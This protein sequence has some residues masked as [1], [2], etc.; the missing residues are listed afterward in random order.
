MLAYLSL[1][2][3]LY[4]S[5]KH[6]LSAFC[7]YIRLTLFYHWSIIPHIYNNNIFSYLPLIIRYAIMYNDFTF[8]YLM[9]TYFWYYILISVPP[10]PFIKCLLNVSFPISLNVYICST[11]KAVLAVFSLLCVVVCFNQKDLCI[12]YVI[13][14]FQTWLLYYYIVY[15]LGYSLYKSKSTTFPW[16]SYSFL[17]FHY[18]KYK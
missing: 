17:Q 12:L 15:W 11:N 4:Y 14:P 7:F 13:V 2:S 5:I 8:S 18:K 9:T 1:L 3:S 10:S 6:F 16:C